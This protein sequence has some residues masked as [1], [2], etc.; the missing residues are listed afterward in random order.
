MMGRRIV[1][2]WDPG[3][4][5]KRTWHETV[6][7]DG[8]VRSVRLEEDGPKIHHIFDEFGNYEGTR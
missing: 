3:S 6:D 4:G 8:R 7:W 5:L 2:E 1:R